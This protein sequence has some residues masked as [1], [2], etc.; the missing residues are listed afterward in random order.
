VRVAF[1]G[2]AFGVNPTM[3]V[4]ASPAAFR[5]AVRRFAK[6]RGL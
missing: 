6:N 1:G 5:K 4:L 3:T 2:I